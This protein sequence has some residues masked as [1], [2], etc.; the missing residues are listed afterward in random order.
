MKVIHARNVNDAYYQGMHLIRHEGE[1]VMTRNGL[2]YKTPFPVTTIYTHPMERVLF[3]TFRDANPFFHFFEALWMLAG[4]N[5]VAFVSQ[6]ASKMGDFSD[7][8]QTFNAAY[9]YRWRSHFGQDQIHEAIKLLR[10]DPNTRRC[11][12]GMWDASYDLGLNSKDIPCNL[13]VKLCIVK[14]CLEMY[15]FNRSND[16]IWGCYGAN[17]VHMSFLQEYVASHLDCDIGKYYQISTDYHAYKDVFDK[18]VENL[19]LDTWMEGVLGGD[20][21]LEALVTPYGMSDDSDGRFDQD[22]KDLFNG[23]ESAFFSYYFIN[24]VAPMLHAFH[25][26]KKFRYISVDS[27]VA[28]DWK[29]AVTEW[30]TRRLK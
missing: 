22:L 10:T 13:G 23:K 20:P 8:G 30:M 2:A 14:G 3:D 27:I 21:Y 4:R 25:T 28:Q 26:W 29:L 9:G 11:V 18:K 7:D 19:D 5:D 16:I 24:V 17:M 12:I 15:V 1:E 6:F